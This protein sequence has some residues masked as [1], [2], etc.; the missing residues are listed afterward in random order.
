M[1]NEFFFFLKRA[2]QSLT[3]MSKVFLLFSIK[4]EIFAISME[5][6]KTGTFIVPALRF[7]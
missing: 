4:Y 5:N 1:S 2:E 6:K 7:K 3:K